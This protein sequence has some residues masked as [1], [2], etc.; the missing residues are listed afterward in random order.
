[1]LDRLNALGTTEKL[2]EAVRERKEFLVANLEEKLEEVL[3]L[4]TELEKL[5]RVTNAIDAMLVLPPGGKHRK[6][7]EKPL[8]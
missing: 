7:A 3:E 2:A 8:A 6:S 5:G 1:M 4:L